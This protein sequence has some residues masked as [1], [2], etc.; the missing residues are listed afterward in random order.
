MSITFYCV[1]GKKLKAKA[2]QA[3]RRGQCT[4]CGR[5]LT[6]PAASTKP[7]LVAPPSADA[8]WYF[9]HQGRMFGPLAA[10]DLR[11]LAA[12]GRLSPGDWVLRPG[13]AEWQPARDVADLSPPPAALSI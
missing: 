5:A 13:A 1:C 12:D 8:L 4:A 6:I 9:S 2:E 3:G 7:P 10:S 11:E